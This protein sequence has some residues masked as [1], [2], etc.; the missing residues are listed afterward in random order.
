MK[1]PA[2]A[3]TNLTKEQL[4]KYLIEY[5]GNLTKISKVLS[6]SD[7][8]FKKRCLKEGLNPKDYRK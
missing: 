8:G 3:I 6:V 1:R 7:N 2:I 4:E 5:N